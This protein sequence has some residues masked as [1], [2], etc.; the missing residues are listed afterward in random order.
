MY[1][2]LVYL[3]KS[4]TQRVINRKNRTGPVE[5]RTPNSLLKEQL[6]IR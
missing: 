2:Q 6:L 3:E 4:A 1:K 5:V